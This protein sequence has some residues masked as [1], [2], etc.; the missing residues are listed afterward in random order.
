MRSAGLDQLGAD[1]LSGHVASICADLLGIAILPGAE[2]PDA[3]AN[4]G[5]EDKDNGEGSEDKYQPNATCQAGPAL[6]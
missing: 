5:D 1:F 6:V 3:A 4:E 2:L